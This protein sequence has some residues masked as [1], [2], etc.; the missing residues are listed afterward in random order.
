[1]VL[2]LHGKFYSVILMGKEHRDRIE[3]L[4]ASRSALILP[5][6]KQLNRPPRSYFC[7]PLSKSWHSR[8]YCKWINTKVNFGFLNP[9]NIGEDC[10]HWI[11]SLAASD[12]RLHR[13]PH[14]VPS[15]SGSKWSYT[16]GG[17]LQE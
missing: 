13:A 6:A 2:I 9:S 11:S 1:M 16:T 4:I 12:L 17:T 5:L 7:S 10:H 14:A 15:C 8:M 3:K